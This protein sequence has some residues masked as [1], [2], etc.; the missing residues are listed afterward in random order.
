[1]GGVGGLLGAV[2]LG[3][4]LGAN[5]AANL[6]GPAVST[7]TMRLRTAIGVA[8]VCVVLGAWTGSGRAQSTLARLGPQT[9]WGAAVIACAAALAMTGLVAL[10]LPASG[11]Q[12]VVG[13]LVGFAWSQGSTLD[14][15]ILLRI[16]QAWVLTP[17]VASLLG[18]GGTL[19]LA[20][21]SGRITRAGLLRLDAP[22][23]F[24]MLVTVAASAYAFGA[25]NAANVS[26]LTVSSGVLGSASASWIA[27]G[28]M[29]LGIATLGWRTMDLFGRGLVRLEPPTAL[30]TLLAQACTVLLFAIWGVPVS[31]SQAVAGGALGIGLAKG[32]RT[33]GRRALFHVVLGWAATP[34]VGALV[35]YGLVQILAPR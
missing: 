33:I 7:R 31:T 28:S 29:A 9:T 20:R 4:A 35:A 11:S 27:G 5:D 1:V 14:P 16:A 18:L 23:R 30:I 32:V 12:A 3:W 25:N 15:F 6:F 10:R 8:M 17:L 21:A 13:A 22:L 26:G 34:I 19:L 2:F 24:G